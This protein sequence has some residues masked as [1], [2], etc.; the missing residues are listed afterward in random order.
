MIIST[1]NK[2]LLYRYINIA[3]CICMYRYEDK[4]NETYYAFKYEIY[5]LYTYF[6]NGI[7]GSAPNERRDD[8]K[9]KDSV[10]IH[11][12]CI[13]LNRSREQN[14]RDIFRYMLIV[15]VLLHTK[16][17]SCMHCIHI[18]Q[19]RVL[20]EKE[21]ERNCFTASIALPR[22]NFLCTELITPYRWTNFPI[23]LSSRA[24]KRKRE[25]EFVC[26]KLEISRVV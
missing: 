10:Y 25:R 5:V 7:Y 3:T 13:I 2:S 23:F 21:R 22:R 16:L 12:S 4:R 18:H 20:R 1:F 15:Q 6:A 17:L 19:L 8:N 14:H 11:C 24:R 26:V 9:K